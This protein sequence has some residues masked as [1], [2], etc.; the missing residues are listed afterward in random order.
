MA[1]R[2]YKEKLIAQSTTLKRKLAEIIAKYDE[3]KISIT[4]MKIYGHRGY[5]SY[6]EGDLCDMFDKIFNKQIE[7]IAEKRKQLIER[8]GGSS[9]RWDQHRLNVE[10]QEL[11]AFILQFQEI[12]DLIFEEKFLL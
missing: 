6:K 9:L 7:E 3:S 2:K 11:N 8:Y 1:K 5:L 10:T 12:A 4:E